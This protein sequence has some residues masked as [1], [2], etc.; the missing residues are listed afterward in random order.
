MLATQH[1][2]SVRAQAVYNLHRQWLYAL[3]LQLLQ[4]ELKTMLMHAT[5]LKVLQTMRALEYRSGQPNALVSVVPCPRSTQERMGARHR[6]RSRRR[7]PGA[8]SRV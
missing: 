3:V 6:L 1:G 7:L 2:G 4:R 8:P 5:L